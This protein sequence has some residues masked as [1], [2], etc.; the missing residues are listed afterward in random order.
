[1]PKAANLEKM[2]LFALGKSQGKSS[3]A[4]AKELEISEQTAS[5]WLRDP[6]VQKL[7]TDVQVEHWQEAQSMLLS[8]QKKAVQTLAKLLNSDDERIRLSAAK[9]ILTQVSGFSSYL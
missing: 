9:E 7:I 1:M 8:V 4:L 2:Q 6:R 5:T 3:A